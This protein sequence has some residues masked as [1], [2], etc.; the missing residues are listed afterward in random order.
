MS[1]SP[2]GTSGVGRQHRSRQA[3]VS[4]RQPNRPRTRQT[5]TS[6]ANLRQ[7][8]LDD[9]KW[10]KFERPRQQH[11][12]Q[13]PDH[14]SHVYRYE[15]RWSP[16]RCDRPEL[17]NNL[18]SPTAVHHLVHADRPRRQHVPSPRIANVLD[19]NRRGKSSVAISGRH[20]GRWLSALES[21]GVGLS[22]LAESTAHLSNRDVRSESQETEV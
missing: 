10:A 15:R 3:L 20:F 9:I 11:G 1:Q 16:R 5:V 13:A 2:V 18:D 7:Q 8:R 22:S 17:K 12:R 19:W 21:T 4:L 14:R 6:K